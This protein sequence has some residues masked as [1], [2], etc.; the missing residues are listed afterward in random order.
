MKKILS[1]AL[2]AAFTLTLA[3]CGTGANLLGG[4]TGATSGATSGSDIISG[5]TGILT[6]LL[7]SKSLT[8]KDLYGTWNYKGADC[9]FESENLL[10]KAG[11]AAAA[12]KIESELDSQLAKVGVKPGAC[13]F[14]FNEDK[15]FKAVV[16]GKTVAGNYTYDPSTKKI[17]LSTGL[18]LLSITGYAVRSGNGIS[19]LFD[20]DKALKLISVAGGLTGNST[21]KAITQLASKYDGMQMGLSLKK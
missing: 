6:D 12:A 21:V 13:A 19:L 8:E 17:K 5:L 20:S 1:A 10:L 16:G 14:T 7:G 11:G 4:T 2:I 3:S 15:T 9:V 18:N